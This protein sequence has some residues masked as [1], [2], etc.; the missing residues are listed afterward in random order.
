ML[1][2]IKKKKYFS[3]L[4]VPCNLEPF[5]ISRLNGK[6]PDGLTLVPWKNGKA[7][8]WDFTCPDTLAPS[9][10]TMSATDTGSVADDAEKKKRVKYA[11]LVTSYL[12]TPIAI[13]MLGAF[14]TEATRFFKDVGR[15]LIDYTQDPQARSFLIQRLSVFKR[16]CPI[17]TGYFV[18]TFFV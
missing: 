14:G 15:R 7:L 17:H 6:R 8:L 9:Y 5:G 11:N 10:L 4:G 18:S 16:E 1:R 2:R 13:E 12:F 3:T